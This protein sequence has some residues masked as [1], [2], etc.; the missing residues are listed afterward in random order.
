MYKRQI[1]FPAETVVSLV[2]VTLRNMRF[3][4]VRA[5][6]NGACMPSAYSLPYGVC[7]VVTRD[8]HGCD[9]LNA[10]F[11]LCESLIIF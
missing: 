6:A 7:V 2:A 8:A 3:S 9:G 10:V 11:F 4:S 1:E 5:L